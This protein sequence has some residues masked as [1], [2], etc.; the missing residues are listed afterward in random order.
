MTST[1]NDPWAAASAAP[2][3]S[4]NGAGNGQGGGSASGQDGVAGMVP[5]QPAGSTA[6]GGG[7]L[8]GG[9]G[10][11]VP[12]LLNRGH[13][14][15]TKRQGIIKDLRDVH[16]RMHQREGGELKYW[17]DGNSG[18]GVKPVTWPVSK[19]TGKQN[20]PVM[21]IHVL[22]D[23]DYRMDATEAAL[24][25][26][27][28]SFRDDDGQRVF[29][30]GNLADVQAAIGQFNTVAANQPGVQAIAGPADLIGLG[31]EVTRHN[32]P[33]EKRQETIRLFP[34]NAGQ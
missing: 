15:G 26:R 27:E 29:V 4:N 23:T 7:A 6:L 16:S 11:S 34:V 24:L 5:P 20:R 12:S 25:G 1:Q 22:L 19:I 17:E 31:F 14:A 13:G 28:D 10:K 33:G 8:F 2:S 9:G 18:K 21:D 32:V 30:V 3:T